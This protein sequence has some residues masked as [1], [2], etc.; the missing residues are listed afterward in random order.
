MDEL[1][2]EGSDELSEDTLDELSEEASA[3]CYRADLIVRISV[4]KRIVIILKSIGSLYIA[5]L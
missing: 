3:C 5:C 4:K 2:E 1:S